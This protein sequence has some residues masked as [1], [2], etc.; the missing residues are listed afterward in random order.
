MKSK[1]TRSK[2]DHCVDL[3]RLQDGSF[4]YLLLYLDEMLIASQSLD[5]IEKL[6][7]L[8]KSKLEMKNLSE[9]KMILNME[10]VRDRKLKKLCLTQKQY[11]RRLLKHFRFEK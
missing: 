5:D 8:L 6:K 1:F 3:K 9:A 10:I 11:L 2:Y 4:V 7:T